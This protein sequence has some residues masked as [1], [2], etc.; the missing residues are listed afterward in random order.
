MRRHKAA[1][2]DRLCQNKMP[3]L[4]DEVVAAHLRVIQ[5]LLMRQDV[6]AAAEQQNLLVQWVS[7][8][9]TSCE[10]YRLLTLLCGHGTERLQT[11]L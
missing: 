5:N 7:A 4:W 6:L 8:A 1:D 3:P 2:I 11:R 9:K 10:K